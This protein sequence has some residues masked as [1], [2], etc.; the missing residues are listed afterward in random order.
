MFIMFTTRQDRMIWKAALLAFKILRDQDRLTQPGS[1]LLV[2]NAI[3]GDGKLF[4]TALI[5]DAETAVVDRLDLI[6]SRA[7]L[8]QRLC[9]ELGH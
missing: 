5:P 4:P 9:P 6:N 1:I 7:H 3:T 8:G 2:W